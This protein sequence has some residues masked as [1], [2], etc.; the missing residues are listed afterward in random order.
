M[1]GQELQD[2]VVIVTGST[3]GI[4]RAIAD[5][6]AREGARVVVSGRSE[7]AAE[8]VAKEIGGEALALAADVSDPAAAAGL[9]E[10][11][12]R[13]AGRVDALVNN[14]GVALDNFVTGVTDERWDAVI[15]TNLAGP[16]YLIRATVPHMK[17]QG[18]GV[19]LNLLSWS[20]LRGNVGQAAYSASKA[21]LHGLTLSMAKELGKFGIRVN[22]L[23]PAVPTDMGAEMTED[24]KK[25]A[26]GRRPIK[27]DG[28]PEDV[29]EGA[30][31][32]VSDR[33]RFTTGQVLH[34]DGGLHLN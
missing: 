4:G 34:V 20:G 23:A 18:G 11:T 17:E 6:F 27:I 1:S 8:S 7:A 3:R 9:V 32:L 24:L 30:L 16:L 25:R 29:A 19:I 33:A 5:R 21:G 2:R 12:V 22:G 28:T 31:F 13:E 15:G 26:R 10:R 14:A